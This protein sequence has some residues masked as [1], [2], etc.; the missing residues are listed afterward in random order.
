VHKDPKLK[1]SLSRLTKP[2]CKVVQLVKVE[3]PALLEIPEPVAQ[4][5]PRAALP[6]LQELVARHPHRAQAV[7]LAR[8]RAG[9]AEPQARAL[10]G[11]QQAPPVMQALVGLVARAAVVLL[12]EALVFT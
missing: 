2:T 11:E 7:L 3:D 6:V 8:I 10:Q 9:T 12:E 1:N 4:V 5:A